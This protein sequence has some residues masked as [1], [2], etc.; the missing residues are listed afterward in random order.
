MGHS[1]V[2]I[3]APILTS[4]LCD[5]DNRQQPFG[6]DTRTYNL[7][8]IKHQNYSLVN[9][10]VG[11][12]D[13][14]PEIL[15]TFN[16]LVCL[17]PTDYT[18]ANPYFG[19]QCPIVQMFRAGTVANKF[20]AF[21]DMLQNTSALLDP[22]I[23]PQQNVTARQEKVQNVYISDLRW[24]DGAAVTQLL[25]ALTFL[26]MFWG[27]WELGCKLTLS[28]FCV[29]LAFDAP[30]LAD[31]HSA[32]GAKGVVEE[33]GGMKLKYGVVQD[34]FDGVGRPGAVVATG[35]VGVGDA[36]HIVRPRKGQ[37]FSR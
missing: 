28:T 21:K 36:G 7:L 5:I 10:D 25:T 31:V 34:E 3:P 23:S 2:S 22:G 17:D 26:L 32:A 20:V 1:S 12:L 33:L 8:T 9:G 35:G 13:P 11:Y 29:A 14:T 27:W 4:W 30:I 37:V 24:W 18:T 6:T 19:P 16:S 15:S